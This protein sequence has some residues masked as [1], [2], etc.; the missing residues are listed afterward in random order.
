VSA[1]D[2]KLGLQFCFIQVRVVHATN[3]ITHFL[4]CL[5]LCCHCVKSFWS[6]SVPRTKVRDG[7]VL[8]TNLSML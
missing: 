8:V 1:T 5:I 3:I 2:D 7:L 6:L 4:V